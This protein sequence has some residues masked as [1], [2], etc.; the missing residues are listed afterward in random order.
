MT[1]NDKVALLNSINSTAKILD[2]YKKARQEIHEK[3]L[4]LENGEKIDNTIE[5]E[6]QIFA[7]INNLHDLIHAYINE[8][9][10]EGYEVIWEGKKAVKIVEKEDKENEKK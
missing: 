8:A 4:T 2:Y 5:L 3:L 10:A 6:L 9:A 1:E 7:V